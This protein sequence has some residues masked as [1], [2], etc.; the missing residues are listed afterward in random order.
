MKTG[1]V[2]DSRTGFLYDDRFLRHKTGKDFPECPERLSCTMAH[3]ERQPFYKMLKQVQAEETELDWILKVHPLKH[4]QKIEAACKGIANVDEVNFL[5]M[6][7]DVPICRDSFEIAKLAVGSALALGDEVAQG[8]IN[9]GF[10]LL[11]PP[12]HHAEPDKAMGF[13]LF[14]NIAILAKYLQKKYSIQKVLILDWD[15]HHGNG[16]QKVFY[17]DP[18][19]LFIS[20]H[21]NGL[22]PRDTGLASETGRGK[23]RGT[24]LNCPMPVGAQDEDYKQAFAG[25]I[26]PKIEQYKPEIVLISAGFD[27]HK[28]DPLAEICLTT[29]CYSWMTERMM[30]AAERF[31]GSKLISLLEGGYNLDVLPECVEAHLKTLCSGNSE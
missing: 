3:L 29:E 18:S 31:S 19:V 2:N 9:N 14:S 7:G 1:K 23:G 30:E 10:A 16:T 25:T 4:I 8:N 27:A 12:G 11:R 24:T 26:L 17:E 5:D 13:C 21:Q 20:L 6:D 22:F 28:E 15:V